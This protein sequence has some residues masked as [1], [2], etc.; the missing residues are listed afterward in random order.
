M[1]LST[2]KP[3]GIGWWGFVQNS[4]QIGQQY[5]QAFSTRE[6]CC[7]A[8]GN[9]PL[10]ESVGLHRAV[11][12]LFVLYVDCREFFWLQHT[13]FNTSRRRTPNYKGTTSSAEGSAWISPNSSMHRRHHASMAPSPDTRGLL[14]PILSY[15]HYYYLFH[16]C[17]WCSV[18][19]DLWSSGQF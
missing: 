2:Q 12:S 8:N 11:L 19:S 13:L 3:F 18:D 14:G 5:I 7:L 4:A 1:L 16:W 9:K 15:L 10:S 6:Q 17:H